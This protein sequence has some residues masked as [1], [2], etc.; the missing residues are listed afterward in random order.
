VDNAPRSD[1]TERLVKDSYA[2]IV[3]YVREPRPGLARAHNR[4]LAET[5]RPVVAFTDDDVLVDPAWPAALAATFAADP[6]A[7]CVTGLILPAELETPAQVRLEAHGDFGKG[8]AVR[9][10]HRDRPEADPLFPFTA[11]RFGSGANMAFSAAALQAI[12]GFDAAMGAGTRAKGG[13]D[14]LAFFRTIARGFALV[15]QP[16]ALVWHH[17]RRSAED[18]RNQ[19]FGYGAGLGA[20]LTAAVLAE[21]GLWP[22]L[23]KA[24]PRG[25][26]HAVDH[27]GDRP[28]WPPEL[29]R[30]QR[31]GMVYGPVG[32]LAS[33]TV[34]R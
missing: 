28:G 5:T 31:R 3:R 14:L 32:Y 6:E 22:R 9:T 23:A 16:G 8:F 12:G 7:G 26:R 18:L 30:L 24:L 27:T 29:S 10:F 20:Y 2:D 34:G 13:D 15:Y 17:H 11:G 33:R 21:P 19:A 4:G 25:M 1:D